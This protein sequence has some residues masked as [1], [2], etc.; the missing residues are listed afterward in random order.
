[1]DGLPVTRVSR[2]DPG[3]F[4]GG[5]MGPRLVEAKK[6]SNLLARSLILSDLAKMRS[7][8]LE[9]RRAGASSWFDSVNSRT[10]TVG[11]LDVTPLRAVTGFR[12]QQSREGIHA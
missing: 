12:A 3:A 7:M 9:R 8:P 4:A 5:E 1:M 6:T 10:F 11:Y 2:L